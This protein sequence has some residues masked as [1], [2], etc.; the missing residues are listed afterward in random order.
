MIRITGQPSAERFDLFI[1][2][3][4]TGVAVVQDKRY[5]AMWRIVGKDGEISDIVNLSRAKDAAITWAR[6]R[7]LGGRESAHWKHRETALGGPPV[8]FEG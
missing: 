5:S 3:K 8:S 6:P 1:G 7:G 4:F 2:R